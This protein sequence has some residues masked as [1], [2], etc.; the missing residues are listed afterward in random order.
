MLFFFLGGGG[1]EVSGWGGL[2]KVIFLLWI[3]I[4]NNIFG[5]GDGVSWGEGLGLE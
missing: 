3:Q 5:R 4:Q 1:G 2:G